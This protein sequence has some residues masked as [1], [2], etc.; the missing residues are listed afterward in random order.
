MSLD[1]MNDGSNYTNAK[2]LL[3][4]GAQPPQ[5]I[6]QN[7]GKTWVLPVLPHMAPLSYAMNLEEFD[8]D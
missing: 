6:L 8:L 1:L 7:Q 5:S 3:P 2:N 4:T